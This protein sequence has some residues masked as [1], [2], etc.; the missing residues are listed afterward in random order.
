MLDDIKRVFSEAWT[1][2]KTEAGRR[3]PED[4]VAELLL[5]MRR[6]VVAARADLPLY[7]TSARRAAA[8]LEKERGLLADCLRRRTLA[9]RIGDAETVRVAT[10]FAEKHQARIPV[11]E[12]KARAAA[13]E[14][15]LRQREA[16]EM[17]RKFKDAETNRFALLAEIRARQA[18]RTLGGAMGTGSPLGDDFDRHATRI[19]ERAAYQE[20]MDELDGSAPPPPPPFEP[21]VDDRLAELKRRMGKG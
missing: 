1:A 2:F 21:D 4:Q 20:A 14:R 13:D 6:E 17:T 9:E 10:E 5:A 19:D 15:D 7:D 18:G 3:E 8:D 12:A 11:L 16:E